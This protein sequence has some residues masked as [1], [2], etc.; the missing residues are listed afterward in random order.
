MTVTRTAL[1]VAGAALAVACSPPDEGKIKVPIPP[2]H[3]AAVNA[4][5]PAAWQGRVGFET[6]TLI[7]KRG[8]QG[9][10]YRL[11]L[12]TGWKP[13]YM[14][15]SLQPADADDFGRSP[16]LGAV[17]ALRVTSNCNG[18][19]VPKDWAVESDRAFFHK[20]TDGKATGRV[21][22]DERTPTSRTLV[23]QRDAGARPDLPGEINIL[24]AWWKKNGSQHFLCE[25][26]LQGAAT[27]LA[28]AFELACAV[29][30]AE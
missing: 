14:P 21:V 1:A 12:P 25:A 20:F 23:F 16:A 22:K 19:C 6:G 11:A 28:P 2:E 10:V 18:E 26:K 7:D 3:V 24:R 27:E 15:G 29:V 4:L 13:S 9:D 8:K 30:S 17:L 5:I